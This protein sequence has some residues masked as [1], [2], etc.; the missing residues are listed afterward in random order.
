MIITV[1][2]SAASGKTTLARGLAKQLKFKHI[3]A[4]G[5]MREMACEREQ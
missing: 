4:G 2:G 1:G 3:S 5:I